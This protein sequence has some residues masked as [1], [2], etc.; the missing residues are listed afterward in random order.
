MNINLNM[1]EQPLLHTLYAGDQWEEYSFMFVVRMGKRCESERSTFLYFN[2]KERRMKE[3]T[4]G[5]KDENV[6]YIAV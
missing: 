6:V 5:F 3:E 1:F 4:Q 2:E